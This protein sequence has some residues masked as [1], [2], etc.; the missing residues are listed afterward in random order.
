MQITA[1]KG[2]L[3]RYE[4]FVRDERTL[5][6]IAWTGWR[7]AVGTAGATFLVCIFASFVLPPLIGYRQWVFGGDTWWTVKGAQWVSHGAIGTVYNGDPMYL[8]LPGMLILLAPFT[9]LGDRLGLA[10]NYPFHL[11]HPSMWLIVGPVFFLFGSLALLGI[12]YLADTLSLPTG[13]RRLLLAAIGVT[14]VPATCVWAG[15]PEDLLALG[16]S[17]SSLALLF[18]QRHIGAALALSVAVMMQPWAALLVPVLVAAVPSGWRVR[19]LIWSMALPVSCAGLLY[20]LAPADTWRALAMQ[21][22]LGRGQHLPWW[23]LTRP[24]VIP[25]DG[26]TIP[27]RVGSISRSASVVVAV[28]AGVWSA[29]RPDPRTV[30]AAAS[31]ALLSRGFFETQFWPWYV[32]PAAVMMALGAAGAPRRRWAVGALAAF[33]VYG[34][35][36]A[37]YDGGAM[38]PWLALALL[39]LL[40][41]IGTV[42]PI[43]ASPIDPSAMAS[44]GAADAQLAETLDSLDSAVNYARWIR[45]LASPH[46]GPRVLEVGAGHGTMTDLLVR[47]GHEVVATDLSERCAGI[48]R[49][50]FDSTPA[51]SVVAGDVDRAA[52]CGPFDTAVLINVLEHIEDDGRVIRDLASTLRPGGTVVVWVP[53]HPALYSA[54]DCYVGHHRRYRSRDLRRVLESGGLEVTELRQVNLLGAVAW[55]LLARALGHDPSRPAGVRVFDRWCVPIVRRVESRVRMPFGQSLFAVA[56]VP[57]SRRSPCAVSQS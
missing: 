9:A 30:M 54:F 4:S 34:F 55:W 48:L 19:V 15:H 6:S 18:R 3:F 40:G 17:C 27:A 44:F 10:T 14:V 43:L 28:L 33:G 41:T 46:L 24:M 8:P 25:V 20:A 2:L 52:A 13:R 22:M 23:G 57:E 42:A 36:A 32:A 56:R 12:D 53:A 35:A 51:V 5:P 26:N 37:S 7:F 39:G 11:A 31:V 38:N 16:L 1:R 50:R 29:R 49:R 45:D 21:P 47:D